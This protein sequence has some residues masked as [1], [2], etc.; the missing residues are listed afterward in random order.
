[1]DFALLFDVFEQLTV[2]NGKFHN[3]YH[4]CAML[5]WFIPFLCRYF[6]R[7]HQLFVM[8]LPRVLYLIFCLSVRSLFVCRFMSC[9]NNVWKIK[10]ENFPTLHF[11]IEVEPI[12][13]ELKYI[14]WKLTT[15]MPTIVVRNQN[16]Q[17]LWAIISQGSEFLALLG[18]LI[19]QWK[20]V[21]DEVGK[22]WS[23]N[24]SPSNTGKRIFILWYI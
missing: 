5:Y 21:I 15:H 4:H 17:F 13:I 11:W 10:S 19:Y 1:M 16:Q 8:G 23:W 22:V 24:V 7:T 12:F 14:R 9:K 2:H 6:L 3:L 18:R 20:K